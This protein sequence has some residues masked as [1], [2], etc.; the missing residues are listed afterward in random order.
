MKQRRDYG[1]ERNPQDAPLELQDHIF[2]GLELDEDQVRYR[3]AIWEQ[4]K[5]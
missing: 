2:F 5:R 4:A 1:V 3:D